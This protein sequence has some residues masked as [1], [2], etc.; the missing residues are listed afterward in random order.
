[1]F[2]WFSTQ[3]IRWTR[4]EQHL[5]LGNHWLDARHGLV[6]QRIK[7]RLIE[8]NAKCRHLNKLT[9]NRTLWQVSEAQNPIPP[10]LLHTVCILFHTGKGRGGES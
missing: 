3:G 6:L 4:A 10:P 9:C 8:G 5:R 2:N 7:I 1:M